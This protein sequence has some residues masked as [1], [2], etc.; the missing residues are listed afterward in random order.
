M[1]KPRLTAV[2]VEDQ[3][4]IWDYARSCL[5]PYYEVKAF[6]SSTPEAEHSIREFQPDLVWLDCYLGEIDNM[7]QGL[8]NSGV[9]L[10]YWLRSHYPKT[11]IIL[12]TASNEMSIF[13]FAE[14]LNIEGIALGG[15][16][17]KDQTI[18]MNAIKEISEGKTWISP[19]LIENV[20]LTKFLDLTVLEFCVAS[21]LL[22]GKSTAYIAEE[23][24]I[25]RKH[26]NNAIYRIK[27][28][29]NL[30]DEI[31]RE[32]FLEIIKTKL[33]DSFNPSLYYSLSEMIMVNSTVQNCLEPLLERL[34][35]G[36]FAKLKLS[37]IQNKPQ[38]NS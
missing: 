20:Q 6:C 16:Y 15:K 9:Q 21:S 7:K 23:L 35:D 1:Q 17:I 5:E 18:I 25:T 10:A 11:K 12:F 28:K 29:L 3:P 2:V 13:R 8:K 30:D 37:Q 22:L 31:K 33:L 34:K 38:K 27:Q 19:N 24:D 32:D 14:K 26:V 36:D 4:I